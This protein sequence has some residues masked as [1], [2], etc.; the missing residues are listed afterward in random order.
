MGLKIERQRILPIGVVLGAS[1]P[2][3]AQLVVST[4]GAPS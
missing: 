3:T 1:S 4:D 2:K